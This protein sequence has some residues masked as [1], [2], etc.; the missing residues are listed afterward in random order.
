MG[1]IIGVAL[2]IAAC[3]AGWWL[4]GAIGMLAALFG[5]YPAYDFVTDWFAFRSDL[6]RERRSRSAL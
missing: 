5:F 1:A 6:A 2:W 4:Y 3:V